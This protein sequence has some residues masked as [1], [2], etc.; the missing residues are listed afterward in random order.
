VARNS[1]KY[2]YF[3][4][5]ILRNSETYRLLLLDANNSSKPREIGAVLA[6]RIGDY[7]QGT[8]QAAP[9]VSVPVQ[10][11]VKTVEAPSEEE[12]NKAAMDLASEW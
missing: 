11:K 5:G 10:P 6:T 12:R 2:A 1:K 3:T 7:Y 4:V 8:R 9:L